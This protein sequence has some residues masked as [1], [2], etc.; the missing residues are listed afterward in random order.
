MVLYE[1]RSNLLQTVTLLPKRGLFGELYG[2][3]V[4]F[5]IFLPNYSM[6]T[7]SRTVTELMVSCNPKSR[8]RCQLALESSAQLTKNIVVYYY[9]HPSWFIDL[10]LN[11]PHLDLPQPTLPQPTLDLPTTTYHQPTYLN[12]PQ[13]TLNLSHLEATQ[14]SSCLME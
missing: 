10:D 4:I 13:P 3:K 5:V 11:L 7:S 2:L 1:T 6:S 9:N 14:N 8:A 12:L